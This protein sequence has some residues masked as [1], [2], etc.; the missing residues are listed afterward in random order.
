MRGRARAADDRAADDRVYERFVRVVGAGG[1][2]D[3]PAP[4]GPATPVNPPAPADPRRDDGIDSDPFGAAPA[5][6]GG[7]ETDRHGTGVLAAFD[8]GRRGVRALAAVA[9]L[10]VLVAGFLTW[11]ARPRQQP[12]AEQT[13]IQTSADTSVGTTSSAT[14]VVV[15]VGGKVQRPGLVRLPSGSRVADAIDAAGGVLPGTDL[16]YLNLARK[17]VDG[18]LVLVGITPSGVAGETLIGQS[19]GGGGATSM[20]N[21]NTANLTELQTLPGIGPVL[22]QRIIDYRSKHGTFRSVNDLRQ[23]TGIGDTRFEQLKDLVTV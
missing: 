11:R 23:V 12:V 21:L 8:P 3:P 6:L 4:G 17:L 10:V 22:A 14:A 18:E 20:V 13:Q 1:G 15:A 19:S 5:T 7:D 9:V 16:S 2:V